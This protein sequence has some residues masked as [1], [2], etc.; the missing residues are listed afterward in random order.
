MLQW[1]FGPS[2]PLSILIPRCKEIRM[3]YDHSMSVPPPP[4][5]NP[6]ESPPNRGHGA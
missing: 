4:D 3:Y 5:T 6:I 1:K 2:P